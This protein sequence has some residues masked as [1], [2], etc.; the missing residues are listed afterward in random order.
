MGL[1]RGIQDFPSDALLLF[2]GLLFFFQ[3]GAIARLNHRF[4]GSQVVPIALVSSK[5]VVCVR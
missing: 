3:L 1:L 2:T 5:L 4:F